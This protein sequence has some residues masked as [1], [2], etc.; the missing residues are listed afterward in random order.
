MQQFFGE[1]AQYPNR[2]TI[3]SAGS[4]YQL[5]REFNNPSGM[6]RLLK[7]LEPSSQK[8]APKKK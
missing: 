1:I 4:M 5:V 3:P 8:P 2:P 6:N 7:T